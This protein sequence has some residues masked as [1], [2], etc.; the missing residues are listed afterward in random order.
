MVTTVDLQ[1][2]RTPW[3]NKPLWGTLTYEEQPWWNRPIWGKVN[4]FKTLIAALNKPPV[5]PHAIAKYHQELEGL[6]ELARNATMIHLE[7]FSNEEFLSFVKIKTSINDST[8]EYQGLKNSIELLLEGLKEEK[9]FQTLEQLEL[10]Y[11][12]PKLTSLYRFVTNL[13]NKNLTKKEFQTELN[14]EVQ[15]ILSQSKTEYSKIA[16]QSYRKLV[17]AI[18]ENELALKLLHGFKEYQVGNYSKLKQIADLIQQLKIEGSPNREQL[19]SLIE[20][21]KAL[22]YQI[23]RVIG[24]PREQNTVEIQAK[25]FEYIF[26]AHKY[27]ILDSRFQQFMVVLRVWE[28]H[29]QEVES[30]REEYNSHQYQQPKDFLEEIPGLELYNKYR[31]YCC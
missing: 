5:D 15:R 21:N 25:I 3:W 29:Y 19:M 13:L 4:A 9:K 16:L 8:G 20:N 11:N 30:I 22:F 23:V 2:E 6:R 7:E 12:G 18:A 26:L 17:S 1:N 10:R 27:Q 14:N 24:I 28:S 31:N